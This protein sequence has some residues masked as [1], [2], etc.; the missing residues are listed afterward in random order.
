[1][2]LFN[3][4]RRCNL[5]FLVAASLILGRYPTVRLLPIALCQW[6]A[7]SKRTDDA[8]PDI[9]RRKGSDWLTFQ[10]CAA[11]LILAAVCGC[12]Y[13]SNKNATLG[14]G[15]LFA[16]VPLTQKVFAELVLFEMLEFGLY[17]VVLR[18]AFCDEALFWVTGIS[19][20]IIPLYR[21]TGSDNFAMR[22]SIGPLLVVM[23]YIARYFLL[24]RGRQ[25]RS[26]KI[27]LAVLLALG[28]WTSGAEIIRS[29][30]NYR[31]WHTFADK[32]NALSDTRTD[33]VMARHP[34]DC[35]QY[36][37]THPEKSFFFKYL[38]K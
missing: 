24:E 29:V 35:V 36:F 2:L 38:A 9:P 10:N 6:Y 31:S 27:A 26:D 37:A 18:R 5:F 23:V 15:W 19:L 21:S 13:L 20:V 3:Q 33:S 11:P 22:A 32:Y 28:S 30:Q 16:S 12:Y 34:E 1:M 4:R 17:L 14:N 8:D 25:A 7:L